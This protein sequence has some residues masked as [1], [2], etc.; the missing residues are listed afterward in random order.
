MKHSKMHTICSYPL[1][2]TIFREQLKTFNFTMIALK[3]R[4]PIKNL[5]KAR[6][7][8]RALTTDIGDNA[9]RG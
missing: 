4:S 7:I 3:A 5:V 2:L 6:M 1:H 8:L 9:E